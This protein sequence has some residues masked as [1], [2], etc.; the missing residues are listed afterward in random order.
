MHVSLQVFRDGDAASPTEYDG[1]READGIVSY[2]KKQAGPAV[3]SLVD[4]DAVKEFTKL[5]DDR[6]VVGGTELQVLGCGS[7]PNSV[8]R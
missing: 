3:K 8:L 1:P 6:D 4:A 5:D 2:L 7:A